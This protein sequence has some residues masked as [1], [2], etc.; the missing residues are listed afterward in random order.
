[1]AAA[2]RQQQDEQMLRIGRQSDG[3]QYDNRALQVSMAAMLMRAGDP[4]TFMDFA[5]ASHAPTSQ[6]WIVPPWVSSGFK[7]TPQ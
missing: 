6:P 1:M 3:Q 4:G 5:T 2:L 7:P